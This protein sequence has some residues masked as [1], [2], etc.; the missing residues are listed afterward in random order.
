MHQLKRIML[1]WVGH[2]EFMKAELQNKYTVEEL[3]G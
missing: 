1:K 2:I 3:M